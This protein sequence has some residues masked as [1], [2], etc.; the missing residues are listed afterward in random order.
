M[1]GTLKFM[2]FNV[3][4]DHHIDSPTTPFAAPPVREDPFDTNQ[5][6]GEQPW[7][8]RKWKIADTILLY[9]PDIVALQEPVHH[10]VL[11][12]NALLNDNYAWIGVGRNDGD[13][14]GEFSAL[15][16][17]KSILSVEEWKTIWLS[18]EPEV[19]GSK[20]WDNVHPRT[21]IQAVFI[22]KD[23]QV[24]FTVF[25][26]HLDHKG[27]KS[28]EESAKLIL[29]RARAASE[30]GA[31]ILLGDL[32]STET[33]VAYNILTGSLYRDSK[34]KNDTLANLQTL[35]QH[36]ASAHSART[37]E[38]V[39]TAENHITLPTHRV[40]RPGQILANLRQQKKLEDQQ[41]EA[42]FQDAYYELMTRLK[43][44]GAPDA[45]SG[46]YGYRDTFT[47]FGSGE[48]FK[49]A[50]IRI[51]FIMSLQSNSLRV[52]VHQFAVLSNQFDDGLIISD[53]RPVIA[54]LSW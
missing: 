35:N 34:G 49:R 6:A 38:P 20:S 45:L 2:T 53:H 3:R 40:I 37:G 27:I 44:E 32:N 26:A 21:A 33:D 17:K 50:P 16:Y 42:Y 11:D 18:E 28:R 25:N 47:S 1:V 41:K 29:E 30:L 48:E 36:S 52:K 5:F 10:Q 46:P 13:K 19:A 39:H 12:L 8:I 7:S 23:E 15:F 31:V 24:K 14:A 22:K 4:H 43:A 54:N 51:D 9:S